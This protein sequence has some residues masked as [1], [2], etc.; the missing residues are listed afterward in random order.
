M[1]YYYVIAESTSEGTEGLT[2]L[3]GT[4]A[5]LQGNV[6][7][8]LREAQ[9][10]LIDIC[11][12]GAAAYTKPPGGSIS[13]GPYHWTDG[14]SLLFTAWDAVDLDPDTTIPLYASALESTTELLL[15]TDFLDVSVPADAG[16]IRVPLGL[17]AYQDE[18]GADG[19]GYTS[20]GGGTGTSAYTFPFVVALAYEGVPYPDEPT[21][22][23]DQGNPFIPTYDRDPGFALT[24]RQGPVNRIMNGNVL[25]IQAALSLLLDA[26]PSEDDNPQVCLDLNSHQLVDL[27]SED[28]NSPALLD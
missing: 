26:A 18:P 4:A 28:L 6:Y 13:A 3:V 14:E 25:R 21:F 7:L 9:Q 5:S 24:L 10:A 8:T 20:D 16:Y 17:E 23:E 2:G 15:T 11:T 27:V 22:A 12:V 1:A 19:A